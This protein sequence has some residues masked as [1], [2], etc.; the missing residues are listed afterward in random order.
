MQEPLDATRLVRVAS[1]ALAGDRLCRRP[2]AAASLPEI[3]SPAVTVT[4]FSSEHEAVAIANESNCGLLAGVYSRDSATA[5][6][7]V[8]RDASSTARAGRHLPMTHH[9]QCVATPTC[10]AV[11]QASMMTGMMRGLR[12]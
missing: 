2:R 7:V 4:V 3:F 10:R 9:V 1:S 11:V 5:S 8:G 12:R 6:R